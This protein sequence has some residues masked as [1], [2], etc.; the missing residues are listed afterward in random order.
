[1]YIYIIYIYS[2]PLDNVGVGDTDTEN[3][4][5]TLDSPK[6]SLVIAYG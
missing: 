4:C 2:W 1:M 5:I 6:T 3:P